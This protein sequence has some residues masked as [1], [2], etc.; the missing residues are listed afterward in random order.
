MQLDT[1]ENRRVADNIVRNEVIC[2][3]S[4]LIT[5]ALESVWDDADHPYEDL[6]Y[7]TY[8]PDYSEAAAQ[9]VLALEGDE[10][11]IEQIV[12]WANDCGVITD[13]EPTNANL[14]AI[15]K[16]VTGDANLGFDFCQEFG[17]DT[18]TF[19]I[20]ALEYWVVSDMLARNLED[21]GES[22]LHDWHGLTVWGRKTSGQSISADAVMLKVAQQ[23]MAVDE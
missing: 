19:E 12:G 3:V 9:T 15:A 22:I 5:D 4:V 21:L 16:V 10:Q 8:E 23:V 6:L 18:D 17:I 11:A 14:Q 2:N 13:E 7:L 1:E 20:E